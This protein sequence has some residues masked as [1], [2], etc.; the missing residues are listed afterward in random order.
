M[1]QIFINLCTTQYKK[2]SR[3]KNQESKK[4][5]IPLVLEIKN[6]ASLKTLPL[7]YSNLHKYDASDPRPRPLAPSSKLTW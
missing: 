7:T 5:D 6:L 4:I 2:W 3:A 1:G